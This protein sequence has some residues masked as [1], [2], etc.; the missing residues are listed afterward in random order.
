METVFIG[1]PLNPHLHGS[2][3]SEVPEIAP[4]FSDSL[5]GLTGLN[6]EL[7]P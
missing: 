2:P 1:F 4:T 5:E 7:Y 6:T 3:V